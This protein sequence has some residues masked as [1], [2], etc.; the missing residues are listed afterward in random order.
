MVF[1]PVLH[2]SWS[3]LIFSDQ[4]KNLD[5]ITTSLMCHGS[6]TTKGFFRFSD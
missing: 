6:Y 1:N 5:W 2:Q 4:A 3:Q